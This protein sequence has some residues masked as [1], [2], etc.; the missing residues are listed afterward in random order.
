MET[1]A[2]FAV[3]NGRIDVVAND[4]AAHRAETKANF[5]VTNG[6][7]DAVARDLKEHRADSAAHVALH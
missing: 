3:T 4:L 6:K 7:I 5:G 1:K 2:N